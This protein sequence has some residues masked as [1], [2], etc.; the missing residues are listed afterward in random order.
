MPQ[1]EIAGI[2]V[3]GMCC[4]LPI[5]KK[6]TTAYYERF[7]KEHV[8][9]FIHTVGV[10]ST[11]WTS[12]YQTA[13]D[14]A[15]EAACTLLDQKKVRRDEIGI[16]VFVTGSPDY[17]IP[18][19][20]FILQKRLEIGN[21]C[22]C[23]DVNLGCSAFVYGVS[24]VADMMQTFHIKKGL[25]L[26]GDTP[27][28]R[29]SPEDQ[30]LVMLS[31]DAGSA[32]LLEAAQEEN[33]APIYC[34]LRSD[35]RGYQNI[36]VPGGGYRNRNVSTQRQVCEDGILRAPQEIHMDGAGVFAFAITEA[37]RLI[38]E[39]LKERGKALEDYDCLALHQANHF[40]LKQIAKRLR[41]AENSFPI[42][43]KKYGN[44][45]GTSISLALC[46]T[47][48]LSEEEREL[49]VLCCGFGVG[50]SWG[51]VEIT[52]RPKDILPVFFTGRYYQEN[53]EE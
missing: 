30:T 27:T 3:A 8:D 41:I 11:Y 50:L 18:A 25:L 53:K 12:E 44:T 10:E 31:S 33:A 48:G 13:A 39:F 45:S 20:S 29:I 15:Y 19:T 24:I 32:V 52:L 26:L 7:G 42:V 38:R 46:D 1:G 36:I 47:Y 6:E 49:S 51:I 14:L 22:I 16:L 4:A 9:K 40:I 2:R 35:G 28:K 37:P 21:D 23:F 5:C 43:L 17:P 34:S